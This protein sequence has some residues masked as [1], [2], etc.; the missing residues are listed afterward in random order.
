MNDPD[1]FLSRWSRRK[2]E[3]GAHAERAE[4]T[5]S[6]EPPDDDTKSLTDNQNS[7]P[8][9]TEV[10]VSRL[11]PIDSIGAETDISSFL[12]P[13]VPD[14]LRHAAL[15]RAWSADPAIRELWASPKIIGTRPAPTA[16]QDLATLTRVLTSSGWSPN[17]LATGRVGTGR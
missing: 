5:E 1:N 14:A 17:S 11:P 10:D 4:K 12:R 2:S 9:A 6:G 16:F 3:T 7:T 15:R 13:G 8:A